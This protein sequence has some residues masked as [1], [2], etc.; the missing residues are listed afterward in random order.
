MNETNRAFRER[1][2]DAEGF[3]PTLK[4]RHHK[5]LQAMFEKP[6]NA[7]GRWVWLGSA[8]LGWGFAV[9]FGT[10]AV[11]APA[12]FPWPGRVIFAAGAFFGVGWG[13]LALK[14][15]RRGSLDLKSDAWAAG[16]A[17]GF[18]VLVVTV[19]MVCAPDNIVGLRMILTCLVFLVGGA[20]ALISNVIKQSELKTREKL[21][22]IEYRMAELADRMKPERPLPPPSEA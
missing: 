15:L 14:V 13:L 16:M 22:E 6:L 4:E 21:L 18:P 7:T 5:E 9:L 10:L 20:V 11:V 2:L 8:I 19:A 12:E 1:L 3:T 17:W